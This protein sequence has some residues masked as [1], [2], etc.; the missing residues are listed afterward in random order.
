MGVN[1]TMKQVIPNPTGKG[2]FGDHPEN[3]GT[4][5]WNSE[6]TFSYQYKKFMNMEIEEFKKWKEKNPKRTMV[7]ELAW[8]AVLSA[9]NG[10]RSDR[11]EIANRTEGM[12]KQS[13]D[14]TSDGNSLDGLIKVVYE[15]SST[16][17]MA[18][19]SSTGQS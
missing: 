7:Q 6:M 16:V 12:P 9:R 18:D 11:L 17:P 2:G 14:L 10:N 19:D 15:N 8:N 4:G 5:T 13:T 3:R 1:I